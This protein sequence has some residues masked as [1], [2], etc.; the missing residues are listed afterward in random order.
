MKEKLVNSKTAKLAK[1]KGFN[2]LCLYCYRISDKVLFD[3]EWLQEFF[4]D[5]EEELFVKFNNSKTHYSAPT[6]SLLQKYIR[7]VYNIHISIDSYGEGGE[8]KY[9]Y[10]LSYTYSADKMIELELD[11]LNIVGMN[12]DTFEEALEIG[13]QE[14]LKMIKL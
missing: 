1:E 6:Q 10:S 14:E 4:S 13:L 2:E 7:D 3:I 8:C 5:A 9:L 12:F 11:D